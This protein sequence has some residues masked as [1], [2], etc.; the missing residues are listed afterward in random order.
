MKKATDEYQAEMDVIADFLE[1]RC[2]LMS[3]AKAK[4]KDLYGEYKIWCEENGEHPLSQKH[5]SRRLK[6]RGFESKRGTGGGY[7][8]SGIGLAEKNNED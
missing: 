2:I 4:V 3:D 7:V 5:L 8:W 1:D 6:E